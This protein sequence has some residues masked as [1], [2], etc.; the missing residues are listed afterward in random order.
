MIKIPE[1]PDKVLTET[2]EGAE[3]FVGLRESLEQRYGEENLSFSAYEDRRTER[4]EDGV[5]PDGREYLKEATVDID[6]GEGASLYVSE[7]DARG[8][9]KFDIRIEADQV[10]PVI[11]VYDLVRND[12][13]EDARF[14]PADE[15]T[16]TFSTAYSEPGAFTN[17]EEGLK[18]LYGEENVE[19]S[20][21][22]KQ[23][24]TSD[25]E[26]FYS[27][28]H[29]D[30]EGEEGP[31]KLHVSGKGS[32]IAF[33]IHSTEQEE[34][35]GL[36]EA[37]DAQIEEDEENSSSS[38]F[39]KELDGYSWDDIG[40]L[41]DVKHT[42]QSQLL[43]RIENPEKAEEYGLDVPSGVLLYGPPGTG[44]TLTAKTLASEADMPFYSAS[45]NDFTSKWV[46]ETEASVNQIFE[47]AKEEDEHSIVFLDEFEAVGQQ[48]GGDAGNS[49][50]DRAVATLLENIDGLEEM[51]D[52]TV[53]AAT[54]RLDQV[55][56]ALLRPGR[57][58]KQFEV[59][60]P[61][62]EGR[63]DILEIHTEDKP[64]TEDVDLDELASATEGKTGADLEYLVT[65]ATEYAFDRDEG[66]EVRGVTMDDFEDALD[67][68]EE[69]VDE[70][71]QVGKTYA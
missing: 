63:R 67:E 61:D 53:M 6:I 57:I 33:T 49:V 28:G 54:N 37:L 19:R 1:N 68:L 58:E 17:L 30:I 39:R 42:L 26:T 18:E 35:E 25:G 56:D 12:E 51:D 16:I 24:M 14:L 43:E 4:Y 21:D 64:L 23:G 55:D 44:K 7:K 5:L 2:V 9:G 47:D 22:V 50:M 36:Y 27:E 41:E 20:G 66:D 11:D 70:G 69:E 38:R 71:E 15:D 29:F 10:D 32:N 40:G 8:G 59:D 60:A 45:I 48:R 65:E 34:I 3:N 52:V 13:D 62:Y 46:G 31:L